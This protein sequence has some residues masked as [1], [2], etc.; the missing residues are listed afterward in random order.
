MPFLFGEICESA[1]NLWQRDRHDPAIKINRVKLGKLIILKYLL[2][3]LIIAAFS[4]LNIEVCLAQNGGTSW[5]IPENISN[6]PSDSTYPTIV[7]DSFGRV[8]VFWTENFVEYGNVIYYTRLDGD[9]WS[10]PVDILISPQGVGTKAE[11]TA[12]VAG[13]DDRIHLVFVGG[14]NGQLYY[15]SADLI[16]AGNPR[17]WKKPVLISHEI[18]SIGSPNV[19]QDIYGN[20][21]V[22]YHC[23]RGYNQ[24]IYHS[25]S[26]DFGSSWSAPGLIPGTTQGS[27]YLIGDTRAAMSPKGDVHVTWMWTTLDL[28]PPKGI[29][30]TKSSNLGETWDETSI[31]ADGPYRYP[32]VAVIGEDEVQLVWSGTLYDR[33][34]FSRHS[35]DGGVTWSTTTAIKE[36]GGY[37]GSMG[38]TVDGD[39]VLHM[40]MAASNFLINQDALIHSTWK[41][42]A[43]TIPTTLLQ[44]THQDNNLMFTDLAISEGKFVHIVV[45]Y[46]VDCML[47]T[48]CTKSYQFEIYYVQGNISATWFA[49]KIAKQSKQDQ[50]VKEPSQTKQTVSPPLSS[51]HIEQ[52]EYRITD[53]GMRPLAFVFIGG[54]PVLILIILIIIGRRYFY[55]MR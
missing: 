2:V 5:S 54:I 14:W 18:T 6:T 51:A 33:Y 52:I 23:E 1:I 4:L 40:A 34:K 10:K 29:L 41:D 24:G 47:S 45:M 16:G 15:S 9:S 31:L 55:H 49:P 3:I 25:T 17:A 44:N 38:M 13:S 26:S 21:H 39:G 28:Y 35:L 22:F 53:K 36:L 20:L 7:A 19:L 27:S 30:Y 48:I 37:Q 50:I 11:Q 46:P 8:H 32:D 12:V 43:W 42:F